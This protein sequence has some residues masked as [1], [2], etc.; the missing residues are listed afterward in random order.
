MTIQEVLRLMLLSFCCMCACTATAQIDIGVHMGFN[1]SKTAL[2]LKGDRQGAILSAIGQR[3]WSL[4]IPLNFEL[5]S[6]QSI[7][8]EP[9]F[10][11]EGSLL[12]KSN[13]LG[14]D[15][16]YSI[17]ELKYVRLPILYKLKL[18]QR[19]Y[20][21]YAMLGGSLSYA[22]GGVAYNLK[23]AQKWALRKID[24]KSEAL[25]RLDY[26]VVVGAGIEKKIVNGLAVNIEMRYYV[27]LHNLMKNS[28]EQIYNES[29]M[30]LMGVSFPLFKIA[31]KEAE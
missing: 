16:F 21:F 28:A 29:Y 31:E 8:V 25:T 9:T 30:V 19:F 7:L 20:N 10:L 14:G 15:D 11:A 23:D 24:F 12:V 2:I 5:N 22:V 27:G 4:G 17:N 26:G 13:G 18:N 1:Q 3:K 6:W